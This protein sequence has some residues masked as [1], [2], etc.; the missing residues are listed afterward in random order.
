MDCGKTL[1]SYKQIGSYRTTSRT[2]RVD[3]NIEDKA[4]NMNQLSFIQNKL[5]PA[6][7]KKDKS[8]KVELTL[9]KELISKY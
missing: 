6:S 7:L 1:G 9:V 3:S 4:K 8:F 2:M 5:R